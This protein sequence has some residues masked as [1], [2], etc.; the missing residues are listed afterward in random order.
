MEN[1]IERTK[2]LIIENSERL[3]TQGGEDEDGAHVDRPWREA[4]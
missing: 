1:L 2:S 3:G 4:E